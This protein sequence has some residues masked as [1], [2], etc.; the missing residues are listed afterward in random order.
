MKARKI[1]SRIIFL[2]A[3]SFSANSVAFVW[4]NANFLWI[5]VALFLLANTLCG[6]FDGS[7]KGVRL[8]ICNHGTECLIIFCI[9]TV[10]SAAYHITMFAW[11]RGWHLILMIASAIICVLAH[12]VLFWNGIICV[13]CTSVQLGIKHRVIGIICG[14]IPVANLVVLHKIIK[15][16]AEEVRFETA[17]K[18]LNAE[19]AH[20][21]ICKTKYPILLVH[22]VFFRDNKL[23]NY[24]GR[25]PAE[26]AANGAEVYYG[27]HQSAASVEASAEELAERIKG[28]LRESGAEKVN[29]IAHSKGGLDCRYA[30]C[31]LG[32]A[33]HVASLTTVNTPHRGCGFA[34]YLLEKIP[35][36]VQND[37]ADKYNKAA[38]ALGDTEPD[39]MAAVRD[40][41]AEKCKKLDE[42]LKMPQG[43]FCASIGSVM[44]KPTH[45]KFP[46]NFSY[47]LVKYF[48]GANDGLVSD[49]SFEFGEKYTFLKPQGERG[50]S[51]GDMIDLNRE[52][53]EGFD[54][55]EFYVRLV[56]DLRERGL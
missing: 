35:E 25:V 16:A 23:L 13:Y 17:K 48:D 15:V 43:I 46:L 2:L 38:R 5:P 8:H 36:T 9:S 20:L 31:K 45:G 39:F 56:S 53:I 21:H 42:E 47:P 49:T 33:E 14:F 22:G 29:I 50:I 3:F 44:P 12:A 26:L 34:E 7:A 41:T 4:D 52:N 11:T 6:F 32:M 40:L 24:W 54:V 37:V 10:L 19:R 27:E 28:V 1:F 18:R 55:R 51:H 30:I